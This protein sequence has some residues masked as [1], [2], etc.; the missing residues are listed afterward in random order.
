MF[1]QNSEK[2][3]V[4]FRLI[5]CFGFFFQI[6][7]TP[8]DVAFI[9][10]SE[11]DVS[12]LTLVEPLPFDESKV[13]AACLVNNC[14]DVTANNLLSSLAFAPAHLDFGEVQVGFP[15]E[16]EVTVTN[17]AEANEA[18]SPSPVPSLP[19]PHAQQS[20]S[21]PYVDGQKRSSEGSSG[22]TLQGQTVKLLSLSVSPTETDESS[23]LQYLSLYP[24]FFKKK[25]LEPGE[26]TTFTVTYLPKRADDKLQSF[27][28]VHTHVGSVKLQTTAKSTANSYRLESIHSPVVPVNTSFETDITIYN[29][30][31]IQLNVSELYGSGSGFHLEPIDDAQSWVLDPYETKSVMRTSFFSIEALNHTGFLKVTLSTVEFSDSLILPIQFES[32]ARLGVYANTDAVDF[33][34]IF[35]DRQ[36]KRQSMLLINTYMNDVTIHSITSRNKALKVDFIG[37]QILPAKMQKFYKVASFHLNPDWL[38]SSKD[39]C[40]DIIVR[41]SGSEKSELKIPFR[42]KILVGNLTLH[43]NSTRVFH[44]YS[45]MRSRRSQ[46]ILVKNTFEETLLVSH[47]FLLEKKAPHFRLEGFDGPVKIESGQTVGLG[48]LTFIP[49]DRSDIERDFASQ[50]VTLPTY[51]SEIHVSSNISNFSLPFSC[52]SGLLDYKIGCLQS[53]D[54]GNCYASDR[55]EVDEDEG[56]Q[57]DFGFITAGHPKTLLLT[58]LNN[59]TVPIELGDIKWT[60]EDT[61]VSVV[62]GKFRF[63]GGRLVDLKLEVGSSNDEVTTKILPVQPSRSKVTVAAL[64]SI[65][66]LVTVQAPQEPQMMGGHLIVKTKY[67]VM[68]IKMHYQTLLGSISGKALVFRSHPFRV[69]KLSFAIKNSFDRDLELYQGRFQPPDSRFSFMIVEPPYG[70]GKIK[71][72][73]DRE[74]STVNETPAATVIFD[75]SKGCEDSKCYLGINMQSSEGEQWVSS[76]RLPQDV[77]DVDAGLLKPMIQNYEQMRAD[78]LTSVRVSAF[79][80][81]KPMEEELQLPVVA[82]M[83][84]PAVSKR[85]LAFNLVH[86][87][88]IATAKMEVKNPSNRPMVLQ[89]IP[90]SLYQNVAKILEILMDSMSMRYE[91]LKEIDLQNL[92]SGS[93]FLSNSEDNNPAPNNPSIQYRLD[94][95]RKLNVK[96]SKQTLSFCVQPLQQ[97]SISVTFNASE[98]KLHQS[99]FLIRNNLTIIDFVSVSGHAANYNF[100]L[101]GVYPMTKYSNLHKSSITSLIAPYLPFWN[102][103]NVI[104]DSAHEKSGFS[105]EA[106]MKTILFDLKPNYLTDHCNGNG[107]TFKVRKRR[108]LLLS[109]VGLLGFG[110]HSVLIDGVPCQN[111]GFFVEN[112]DPLTGHVNFS[113]TVVAVNE[114]EELIV[115]FHPDFTL[116][117]IESELQILLNREMNAPKI[118]HLVATVPFTFIPKCSATVPRPPWEGYMYS[119]V[120][121]SMITLFFG[122]MITSYYDAKKLIMHTCS[123]PPSMLAINV[124]ESMRATT[125]SI[126][127]TGPNKAQTVRKSNGS[128]LNSES[129]GRSSSFKESFQNQSTTGSEVGN[130]FLE[131]KGSGDTGS[132][133]SLSYLTQKSNPDGSKGFLLRFNSASNI[134][135]RELATTPSLPSQL[136]VNKCNEA[137]ANKRT[138]TVHTIHSFEMPAKANR[139]AHIAAKERFQVFREKP[140]IR[141]FLY[142]IADILYFQTIFNFLSLFSSL[143]FIRIPLVFYAV[144]KKIY[145]VILY[146]ITFTLSMVNLVFISFMSLF[147]WVVF[148]KLFPPKKEQYVLSPAKKSQSTYTENLHLTRKQRQKRARNSMKM[149]RKANRYYKHAHDESE[150]HSVAAEE[151]DSPNCSEILDYPGSSAVGTPEMRQR[152]TGDSRSSMS[153]EPSVSAEPSIPFMES[154]SSSR[155]NGE[156]GDVVNSIRLANTRLA[157]DNESSG[158]GTDESSSYLVD[159]ENGNGDM[160]APN[161]MKSG[162][163]IYAVTNDVGHVRETARQRMENRAV[164]REEGISKE[165]NCSASRHQRLGSYEKQGSDGHSTEVLP[166]GFEDFVTNPVSTRRVSHSAAQLSSSAYSSHHDVAGNYRGYGDQE[167]D[168]SFCVGQ[169]RRS[170]ANMS[171]L[172]HK[173]TVL[174]ANYGHGSNRITGYMK[175][176][177][178]PARKTTGFSAT[179]ST[180]QG[181][182]LFRKAKEEFNKGPSGSQKLQTGTTIGCA[183]EGRQ[184]AIG[185]SWRRAAAKMSN[186]VSNF[187]ASGAASLKVNPQR[188]QENTSATSFSFFQDPYLPGVD[189]KVSLFNNSDEAPIGLDAEQCD[190]ELVSQRQRYCG[191]KS[192]SKGAEPIWPPRPIGSKFS[193]ENKDKHI[194]EKVKTRDVEILEATVNR[195]QSKYFGPDGEK[196]ITQCR[197]TSA[198]NLLIDNSSIWSSEQRSANEA[199]WNATWNSK[200]APLPLLEF[201]ES[202][203]EANEETVQS[204]F[205]SRE[206]LGSNA[207]ISRLWDRDAL[208]PE[209]TFGPRSNGYGPIGYEQGTSVGLGNGNSFSSDMNIWWKPENHFFAPPTQSTRWP[210]RR[211]LPVAPFNEE[212]TELQ[213]A[214]RRKNND[215]KSEK[216][217]KT[218]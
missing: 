25:Y 89:I 33:G 213:T 133:E 57:L 45:G 105:S 159:D 207:D 108:S 10:K 32:S 126:S 145:A 64:S 80:N 178:N 154:S 182:A 100:T 210:T 51:Q 201:N 181:L 22:E 113:T 106:T 41:I 167:S 208:I 218:V 139:I 28:F 42:S 128:P 197:S 18:P 16:V 93:F 2:M 74:I 199:R 129:A 102:G 104:Q 66:L 54:E 149:G 215:G 68:Q 132:Q 85:S 46:S 174:E 169:Q 3:C 186:V 150:E 63:D 143:L 91:E 26:S 162:N 72:G 158:G 211:H 14:H 23:D 109:N 34:Q 65:S 148:E 164:Y 115:S 209:H 4:F 152:W 76:L 103:A 190:E 9:Q 131:R 212:D 160:F 49:V 86:V 155:N 140:D 55:D 43:K 99:L 67:E 47:V 61:N 62:A 29:P 187:K 87:G 163:N 195:K 111:R 21:D 191:L 73:S 185:P 175:P 5:L 78:G 122:A 134:E 79:M 172:P 96:S 30:Y 121:L 124:C 15:K 56:P 170:S 165:S 53:L 20:H 141:R 75:P 70:L 7:S 27:V 136:R 177:V 40:G 194:G 58:L 147:N 101:G 107:A 77:A 116:T 216:K 183:T 204:S 205:G 173:R 48:N 166:P 97:L 36:P 95:E 11:G 52:Y 19:L 192:V 137:V 98:P 203:N 59:N 17:I 138:P 176:N 44:F 184:S 110:V 1:L 153:N 206:K 198:E 151:K 12:L 69:Q 92:S 196:L 90:V 114:Q 94:I 8:F 84:W 130:S 200:L 135:N 13:A 31:P 156:S 119:A 82:H 60:M 157:S 193:S 142:A 38:N 81:V 120:V 202:S 217:E 168:R 171:T 37:P 117:K 83:E 50:L 144:V 146:I 6:N 125:T 180:P 71:A 189:F 123:N 35:P 39:S 88:T 161:R 24:T 188:I 127:T 112:C 179:L 214:E 118:F